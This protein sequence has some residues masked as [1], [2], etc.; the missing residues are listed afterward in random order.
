[1]PNESDKQGEPKEEMPKSGKAPQGPPKPDRVISN[2]PTLMAAAAAGMPGSTSLTGQ[3]EA[4]GEAVQLPSEGRLYPDNNPA[5]GGLIHVR[6]MT[7]REEEILVTERLQKQGIAIDMI[8]SNCIVTPGINTLDLLSGDRTHILYYLRA[9]SYGPKY[10]FTARLSDGHVQ[11]VEANVA[12]LKTRRLPEDFI[13]PFPFQANGVTYEL[14]L[15]RGHDEQ[16][17]IRARLQEHQKKGAH[18]TEVGGTENLKRLVV[19]VNGDDDPK[20]IDK[21]V[22][23]MHVRVAHNIREKLIELSPGPILLKSVVHSVTG[24]YEEVLVSISETFF[25]PTD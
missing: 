12:E 7:T 4:P 22:S 15:A 18:A 6:A 5:K 1:M 20:V 23:N 17:I 16:A 11:E 21:A 9:I 24:S 14:R 3:G 10:K 2:D 13:E 19:S 25:R 8:L